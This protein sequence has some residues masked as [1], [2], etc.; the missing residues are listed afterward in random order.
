MLKIAMFG[1]LTLAVRHDL[2][3]QSQGHP[4]EP[5]HPVMLP[6]VEP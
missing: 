3:A 1:V 6:A 2:L 4:Q 5:P